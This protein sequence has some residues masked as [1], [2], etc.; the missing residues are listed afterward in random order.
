LFPL[1][2]V[3]SPGKL[4]GLYIFEPRYKEMVGEAAENHTEFGIVPA[5]QEGISTIGCTVMVEQ[6]GNYRPD[7]SFDITARGK[8]RFKI[9]SLNYE[10]SYLQGEVE[11]LDSQPVWIN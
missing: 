11:Y 7:G 10:K 4:V 6:T 9:L 5:T 3:A 8:R 1:H 2:M